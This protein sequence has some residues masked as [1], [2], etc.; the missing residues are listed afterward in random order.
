MAFT[1]TPG[2]TVMPRPKGTN[3]TTDYNTTVIG[4]FTEIVSYTPDLGEI[5][6]LAKVLV[7]WSG[8]SEQ[9][10]RVKLGAEVVAVYHASG[11]LIDWFPSGFDLEGDGSSAVTVEALGTDVGAVLTGFI[12]GE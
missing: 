1:I 8:Y 11:Y 3:R 12:A 5:F 4:S 6:S 10:I 9:Q 2:A 7:T